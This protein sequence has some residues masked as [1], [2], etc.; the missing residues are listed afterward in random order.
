MESYLNGYGFFQPTQGLVVSFEKSAAG[1]VDLR[2]DNTVGCVGHP[3]FDSPFDPG[4]T[5]TGYI[6]KKQ[7]QPISEIPT[8]TKGDGNLNDRATLKLVW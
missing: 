2:L 6:T 5:A 8:A 3:Y 1:V 4:W 7:I